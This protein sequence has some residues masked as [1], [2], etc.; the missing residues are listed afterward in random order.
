MADSTPKDAALVGIS[1][2]SG[3]LTACGPVGGALAFLTMNLGGLLGLYGGSESAPAP[4][5]AADVDKIVTAN[6][7]K[8][9]VRTA[10]S[11]ISS[12]HDWY[13]D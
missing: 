10:W 5:A 3:A 2:L 4:L 6:L 1:A 7:L 9:D 11:Q 8:Q 13:R 12:T